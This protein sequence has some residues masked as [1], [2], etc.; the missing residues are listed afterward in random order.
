MSKSEL[1]R[2]ASRLG[3][4]LLAGFGA[5][6]LLRF[7]GQQATRWSMTRV[8]TDDYDENLA[9]FYSASRR[10]GVQNIIEANLRAEKGAAIAR[11]LGSPRAMLDFSSLMFNVA[12][13]AQRPTPREVHIDLSVVIGPCSK[14]PLKVQTPIIVSAM[15]YGEALSA[16]VKV[17]LAK[18]ATLGGAAINGGEGPFLPAERLAARHYILQ[19]NRATWGKAIEELVQADAIEIQIGQGAM[20]GVGHSIEP[21]EIDATLYKALKIP[22]GSD[23]VIE[24]RQRHTANPADFGAFVEQMRGITGGVPIGAKI[25]AGMDIEQDITFLVKSGVDFIS[26]DG[27]QAATKGSSPTLQDDFGLPTVMALCRAVQQ[28]EK[29]RARERVS[30]IVAGGLFTPGDFLKAMALGADAVYIGTA[31]LF[32]VA[33]TQTLKALPYEPPTEVVWYTG[34][35]ASRFN[36]EQGAKHL[37]NFLKACREEL[38]QGL[39]A[40]GK[41]SLMDLSAEDLFGLSPFICEVAGVRPAWKPRKP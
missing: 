8:M 28:L 30:L 3:A 27:A 13:L 17:A 4:S 1:G 14:R 25:A 40:L 37:G 6:W 21:A 32:A 9:E 41:C 10:V 18:G 5:V 19:Y 20:G 38:S 24:A 23:A 29:L 36:V 12:Q 34:R 15:A 11:P 7:M 2:V 22:R 31:A 16:K 26:I 39:Q 35:Y 33:H